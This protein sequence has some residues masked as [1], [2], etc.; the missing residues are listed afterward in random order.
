MVRNRY[1]R[2]IYSEEAGTRLVCHLEPG[3][4]IRCAV[5]PGVEEWREVLDAIATWGFVLVVL[6]A[7]ELPEGR[8]SLQLVGETLVHCEPRPAVQSVNLRDA[9]NRRC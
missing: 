9:L 2:R 3:D 1:D 7:P 5:A 4:K 8:L 6:A